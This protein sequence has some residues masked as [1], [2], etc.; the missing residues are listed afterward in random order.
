MLFRNLTL[1][2]FVP[3][4]GLAA[5]LETA[6]PAHRLK[7]VAPL[8]MASRG[9]VSPYGRDSDV[10]SHALGNSRLLALGGEDRLLPPA[11]VNEAVAL[12][13]AAL[14]ADRGR[15][16]GARDRKRL[17]ED[18]LHD[19]M[20][21]AF[22]RP[23]R[24]AGYLDLDRGWL[25]I[26]SA[27]RKTAE[28]FVAALRETLGSF[29]AVPLDAGESPR[30]SMTAWLRDGN[31]PKLWQLGEECELKDPVDR[32]AVVK[33]RRQEL[34]ADEVRAHLKS[35]K[36]A[37]MLEFAF[38]DHVVFVLDELLVLR[39]LR[40]L[41]TVTAELESADR[42]SVATEIDARFAVMS[43]TLAPLFEA[44][45]VVFKLAAADARKT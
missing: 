37:T 30:A 33:C 9:W 11:V 22:V 29:A 41:D 13:V 15:P 44:L 35:G 27:S 20:P 24:L 8:T 16:P 17:R 23:S 36:Q 28:G 5:A 45:E 10:L 26:D 34:A 2:R 19:L 25:A 4:P 38:D 39:K 18:V 31:L 42:D 14:A 40:F 32:G 12:K 21:R 6:L 3:D 43:L 1:F 7:P